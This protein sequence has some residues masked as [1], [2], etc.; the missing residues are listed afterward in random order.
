M[1]TILNFVNGE[2]IEPHSQQY[3]DNF[4]PATGLPYS[5]V[6]DSDERDVHEAE[7]ERQARV[8]DRP[9]EELIVAYPNPAK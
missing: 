5:R 7:F 1:K 6:P 4:E 8:H 2:F 3:L 9:G